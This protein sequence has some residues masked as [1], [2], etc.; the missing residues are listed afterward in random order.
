MFK[1]GDE[2]FVF[3]PLNGKMKLQKVMIKSWEALNYAYRLS[4]GFLV[5]KSQIFTNMSDAASYRKNMVIE[6]IENLQK[7]LASLESFI[8]E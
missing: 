1:A 7:E 8:C 3:L 6:E 2:V 4:N 5:V